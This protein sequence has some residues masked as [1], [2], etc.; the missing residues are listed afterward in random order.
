M[1]KSLIRPLSLVAA[2]LALA[3]SAFADGCSDLAGKTQCYSFIY[4]TGVSNFYRTTFNAGGSFTLPDVAGTTGTWSCP[5]NNFVEV[6]YDFGGFET[7]QWLAE[8]NP[9]MRGHGKSVTGGYLYSLKKTKNANCPA[10]EATRGSR[11]S[12]AD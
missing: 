5:G 2:L 6:N 10:A 4:S 3:P 11:A 12:Q 8:V 7:Q 1:N 9:A